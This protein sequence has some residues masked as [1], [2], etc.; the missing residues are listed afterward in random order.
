[1]KQTSL[2]KKMTLFVLVAVLGFFV[3][4]ANQ[5]FAADFDEN[6]GLYY[7]DFSSFEEVEEHA[8][9]VNAQIGEEG[10]ILMKNDGVLPTVDINNISVFGRNSTNMALG[11][12]G[13]GSGN[14][15]GA[16]DIF[17][18]LDD[19]GYNVN[20][21]LKLFYENDDSPNRQVPGMG[22][23]GQ[24]TVGE[25][26]IEKYGRQQTE[27]FSLFN[28]AALVVITRSGAEGGDLARDNILDNEDASMH[29]LEL[30][31]NELDML[32]LVKANFEN[33]IVVVNNS[34]PLELGV[35]E[36]DAAINAIVW[37]GHPGTNAIMALGKIL[38]G[39]VNPS[40]RTVD[41]Y[42]ED[43]KADPT[44]Q[45]FGDNSQN[46][47]DDADPLTDEVASSLDVFDADGSTGVSALSYE[48]GIYVGY[49]YYETR[50][51]VEGGSWYEDNVVYPFGYGLSFTSFNWSLQS[52]SPVSGATLI[53]D[54]MIS[55]TVRVTNIGDVA[56]KDVVELYYSAPY[57][58]NEVEK[59][60]V[61]LGGFAKTGL[62]QPGEH[63]DVTIELYV[64]DMSSYDYNDANSNGHMGYELDAGSYEIKLMR[65]SHDEEIAIPYTIAADINYDTDRIT[66]NT[67]EN[68]FGSDSVFNSLP[69]VDGI[70]MT[71]MSR[72]DFAGTFPV[73]PTETDMTLGASSTLVEDVNHVFVLDDLEDPSAP[74]YKTAADMESEDS[75]VQYTQASEA[76][77]AARVDGLVSTQLKDMINVPKDD[78]AWDAFLNQ[79]SLEELQ[80]FVGN[81]GYRTAALPAV[82]K[83][84]ATDADGPA[85]FGSGFY[86]ASEVTI[87]S[88]WN[89]ELAEMMGQMVGNEALWLGITGWYGPAMNT[90]RNSFAGRNFEYYSEDGF[91]AGKIA[92]ATVRGAQSKGVNTYIK[93]FAVNDQETNRSR[94]VTYLNE[95]SLREIYLKAFQLPVQE[96]GS[97]SVMSA[98]NRIGDVECATNYALLTEVLRDEWGFEGHVVTDYYQGGG[99]SS[100][101]NL[102][103]LWPMGNDIPLNGRG[104]IEDGFYAEWDETLGVAVYTNESEQV[105]PS[106]SQWWA[107][108]NVAKNVLFTSVN[109]NLMGNFIEEVDV[110][111]ALTATQFI[112]SDVSVVPEG[113]T[114]MTVALDSHSE[115][116]EGLTLETNGTLSGT[117]L[118][119]GSFTFTVDYTADLWIDAGSV[120]FT[121]EVAPAFVFSN[122]D[123][124]E[125]NVAETDGAVETDAFVVGETQI[126]YSSRG[127]IRYTTL[128]G[129]E[130][131]ISD[132]MLPTGLSMDAAGLITGTPTTAGTYEFTLEIILS[133]RSGRTNVEYYLPT[134]LVVAA[135]DPL[136]TFDVT[137]DGNFTGATPEVVS[138][139]Q[140]T[141]VDM[142][143]S[144]SR[145]G[146]IFLGW[147]TDMEATTP[148]DFDANIAADVTYYAGWIDVAQ[149]VADIEALDGDF[150]TEIAAVN[151]AIT[152]LQTALEADDSDLADE[153][154]DLNDAIAALNTTIG[155]ESDRIDGIETTLADTGCG[156]TIGTQSTIIF[157][158]I[159]VL[160]IGVA[161]VMTRNKKQYN[162]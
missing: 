1:M 48:E 101:M 143:S 29:Y 39:E 25:T 139:V 64:Q 35:L 140:N 100:Y 46:T 160:V 40:G 13:S 21:I 69:K 17:D 57:F 156:S 87:A 62:L 102:N 137:F 149:L 90:H 107:I 85:G 98:F 36:D 106:Y 42:A 50:G 86:W 146:S 74:W 81:G 161:F 4:T 58:S 96:G 111:T 12:G 28:D 65:N 10:F 132:G 99:D 91:L 134:S 3:V 75:T 20:P 70:A 53:S 6:D 109:S 61:V 147:F 8:A 162:K 114:G 113:S 130:Y 128:E 152:A 138:V 79:L 125:E 127:S 159:I 121:L 24:A 93:H 145:Q 56:G 27:S 83:E 51:E 92:A 68:R 44:F 55:V 104:T 129:I 144:L 26:P 11:G 43:F 151:A 103:E 135:G 157:A 158:T 32:D 31:E 45:N 154:A 131:S 80:L 73:A 41:I 84:Q 136:P 110:D 88:T 67:V 22:G 95:Q 150:A 33:I 118:V 133:A 23:G 52:A 155:T 59:S 15:S 77:V 19:A 78:A 34:S 14:T 54:D 72:D 126:A 117:A 122:L 47:Y 119:S 60:S 66:G 7:S 124:L 89:E 153:I 105:V 37:V 5:V 30:S 116:P 16:K 97:M 49:R 141:P 120:D 76:D 2:F 142:Q 123:D 115:L 71:L 148:V 63:Q 112:S 18:S 108:R 82:G 9:V 38:N 94:L